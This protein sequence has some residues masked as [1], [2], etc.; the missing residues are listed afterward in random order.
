MSGETISVTFSFTNPMTIKPLPSQA[1]LVELFEY[2]PITGELYYKQARGAKSAGSVAG[3]SF[4]N[5]YRY[6]CI[7]YARYYAH[8]II[9][10]MV[11]GLEPLVN[12]DHIDG[13]RSNNSWHNLR[14]ASNS[15]NAINQT[16]LRRN[17][18][19]GFTGVWF[20]KRSNRYIAEAMLNGTKIRLGTFLTAEEASKAYE[21]HKRSV[22]VT[23]YN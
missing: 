16:K 9:W 11:T 18:T 17:N 2:S 22:L 5:G 20:C 10:I 15:I 14:E 6:L 8:R 13:D 7:N 19:S 21:A 3:T 1:E 12:I 23:N 4:P